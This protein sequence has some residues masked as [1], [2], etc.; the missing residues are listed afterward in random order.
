LIEPLL[1]RVI[2]PKEK[3]E[4][5]AYLERRDGQFRLRRADEPGRSPTVY[6]SPGWIDLHAHV[7]DGMTSISVPPD[8]VGLKTGVHLVVDAGSAGE[9]TLPGFMKYVVPRHET[10]IRAW[11]NISS[12]GLVHLRE[13]A[14]LSMIDVERTVRSTIENQPFVCG[15]K[16]RAS[17]NIVGPSGIQPLQLG[18]L[19]ARETGLP[20]MVH[21]GEAPPLIEDV[22]D[23]LREG[24]VVTHCYHG[25]IGNPWERT[26]KPVTALA[27]ALSRGVKL[28]VGHGAASFSFDVCRKALAAGLAPHVISTDVHVRNI[29]GPVFNLS[30]TMSKMLTCGMPL[31]EVIAAVTSNPAEILRMPDWCEL[32]G[33]LRHATLFRVVQHSGGDVLFRDSLGREL[34]PS[35]TIEPVAVIH[36]GRYTALDN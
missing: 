30:T 22:L 9:A 12:I 33:A 18:L 28:D 7:Y 1:V 16:V 4:Y 34:T 20:L 24:D 25:K 17:G 5:T 10:Q 8:D 13:T 6:L 23:L 3:T 14:D 29:R 35:R 36:G 11:L 31:E 32:N 15:I 19:A 26:G 21:I 27:R 2:A